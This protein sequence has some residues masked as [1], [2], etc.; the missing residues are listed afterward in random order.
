M[1]VN[2]SASARVIVN[3]IVNEQNMAWYGVCAFQD[4]QVFFKRKRNFIFET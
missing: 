1:N 4:S 2:A 3:V